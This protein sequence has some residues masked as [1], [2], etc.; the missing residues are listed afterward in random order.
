MLFRNKDGIENYKIY[1]FGEL[2]KQKLF[3]F[4]L[5]GGI[6]TIFGYTVYGLG[7]FI[8]LQYSLA[9]LISTAA[10]IVFNFKTIGKYVFASNDHKL[11]VKFLGVYIITYF[12]N[13]LILGFFNKQSFNLYLAQ[14]ILVLPIACLSY[15]LN[16]YFVFGE[17][18]NET[19]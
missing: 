3:R 2:F 15:S 10:G 18:K 14:A 8:G 16:K 13:T 7:L 9:L 17:S 1:F 19:H 4:L 12:L 11:F 6:N 5:I